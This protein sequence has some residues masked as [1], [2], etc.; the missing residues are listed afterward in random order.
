MVAACYWLLLLPAHFCW[1]PMVLLSQLLA[2]AG[3]SWQLAGCRWALQLPLALFR[4]LLLAAAGRSWLL[5]A[6]AGCSWL[7][8]ARKSKQT[9]FFAWKTEGI[10]PRSDFFFNFTRR[11]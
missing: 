11:I 5:L 6:A 10:L 4:E 3:S 2:A 1:L 9:S 8:Q 7:T